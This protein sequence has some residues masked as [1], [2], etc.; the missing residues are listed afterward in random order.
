LPQSQQDIELIPVLLDSGADV[1]L[2]PGKLLASALPRV[3][4]LPRYEVAGFD[5]TKSFAPAVELELLFLGKKF[6]GQFLLIDEDIGILGR[7][8]LNSVMILLNGPAL[9]WKEWQP[10]DE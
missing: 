1:S 9:S 2:L 5:G 8:V 10:G 7:N 6:S 3:D 4:T